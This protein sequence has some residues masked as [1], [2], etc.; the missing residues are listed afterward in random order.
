MTNPS[1]EI[2]RSATPIIL[3]NGETAGILYGLIDLDALNNRYSDMV[4]DLHAQLYVFEEG[5]GNLVI[6]TF[7]DKPG[8]I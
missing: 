6:D 7:H 3:S 2:I 5:N 1:R 4:M 8:N